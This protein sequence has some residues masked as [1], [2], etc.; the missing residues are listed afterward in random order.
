MMSIRMRMTL[1]YSAILTLT[2][3]VF[4]SVLHTIQGQYTLS[5]VKRDLSLSAQGLAGAW[6]RPKP[7][8]AQGKSASPLPKTG[9]GTVEPTSPTW[10]SAFAEGSLSELR[11][12]DTI[13]VLGAD[14]VS[15]DLA[16]NQGQDLPL[17]ERGLYQLQRGQAVTEIAT[18]DQERWLIYDQ[19]VTI[20]GQV[21]GIIQVGRS[22]ADRDRSLQGLGTTLILGSLLTTGIAFGGGWVLSGMTLRPIYRIAQTAQKIGEERDFTS[23]VQY[24]GPNDELGQLARTFDAMLSR[25]QDAYQQ[26]THALQMQRDF[27]ADVSHELRT[28]LTTIRGNLAL[29]SHTAP[30]AP[31]EQQDILADAVGETERLIRLVSDLLTLA[32]MDAGRNLARE[33]VDVKLLAEDTCRQM[34][35]LE[36]R[37]AIE[38]VVPGITFALADQDALKQVL[39]ILLDNAIKHTDGAIRVMLAECDHQVT[40]SVQDGGPGMSP[41]LCERVFDRFYRGD[42]S[43]STPGFGLGLS[44]ART[45]IEAQGGKLSVDSEVGRGSTFTVRIPNTR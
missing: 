7:S 32:R 16:G 21:L 39:L 30:V 15:L 20:N 41:E 6:T 1:L 14:G 17:S 10:P 43:R 35:K 9:S 42:A 13:G 26:V 19:P 31:E 28:P 40:I 3:I 36:P 23:R 12:R 18:I 11:T 37:R 45:L 34:Q 27:V 38:C 33:A 44:I 8:P 29:L 24:Q 5:M 22:L 4:S 2:L 25:L